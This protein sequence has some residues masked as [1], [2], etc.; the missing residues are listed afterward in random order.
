MVQ[1]NKKIIYRA[2]LIPYV[3]EDDQIVMMFMRP[4]D[5]DYGGDRFQIAKGKVEDDENDLQAAIREAQEELG[6]FHGNVIS[7]HQVGQFMGRTTIFV[8]KVR[9]KDLFDDPHFE[10]GD[11]KWMTL[12][13][14]ID[15]GRDLHKP[16]VKASWR[17]IRKLENMV[18]D[19]KI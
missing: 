9:D 8:S 1:Q 12:E 5:P 2:G 6:L 13:Q 11:T 15:S 10:T 14:F 4:S 18:P 3:V 16:V 17:L 7:T 19:Q